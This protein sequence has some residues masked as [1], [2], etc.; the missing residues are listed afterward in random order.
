[1]KLKD[2]VK[3][4]RGKLL[5]G[6]PQKDI[7]PSRIS[8]DS[9]SIKKND[10]FLAL[11]GDNFDGNGFIVE[12]FRKGATGAIGAG[13]KPHGLGSKLAFIRVKDTTRA[14]QDIAAAHRNN[15]KI[16][17]I[18]VTGSNGKTT[19]KDMIASALSGRYRV[20]KN[21]GTKNNHIGL[22]QTL[23]KLNREHGACVVELGTNHPGEIKI[24]AAIAS[25]DIAV[26]TN[27]GP[28]H[29]EFLGDLDG[30]YKE[31]TEIIRYLGKGRGI[32]V[33]NGD[34]KYLSRIKEKGFRIVRYGFDG[35]DDY[36]AEILGAGNGRASFSVNLKDIFSI[37]MPGIHNIY[38]ALAAIAVAR[39]L[40]VP[41]ALIK[42]SL[43]RFK[44]ADMRMVRDGSEG[45]DIIND[46]YNSNPMSVS[47]ALE[48]LESYPASSRW[49]VF[50][51]MLELGGK[52]EYFHR[53]AGVLVAKSGAD[54]LLTLGKFSRYA[55]AEA[56]ASG[57]REDRLWHCQGHA[58]AADILKRV[59][60]K[61]DVI[62]VKGSR[63][64]KMEKVIEKFKGRGKR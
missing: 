13:P 26:I 57:M 15:F 33:L 42:R 30:V 11:K 12:A 52:S 25:P 58:E 24:L 3:I 62:L 43:A 34:D 39:L 49:V 6:D 1:M 5:S 47:A 17:V 48:V 14:L 22:P 64:M 8:T 28:S 32:L 45:I 50:G 4:T 55:L 37:R 51:D 46:S 16:P 44:P 40:K 9:R 29:L 59:A 56:G 60:A 61:G 63:G 54:G 21:E 31:K 27:I 35:G 20:L 18:A 53:M 38:N 19:V 41:Y 23:L 2:I 10:L 7:D 36:A